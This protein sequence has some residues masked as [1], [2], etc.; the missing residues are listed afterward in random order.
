[1]FVVNKWPP[2]KP[3]SEQCRQTGPVI[4]RVDPARPP[5]QSPVNTPQGKPQIMNLLFPAGRTKG[6]LEKP[7]V[8]VIGHSERV[9]TQRAGALEQDLPALGGQEMGTMQKRRVR[10]GVGILHI[11]DAAGLLGKQ[12]G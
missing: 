11:Q 2:R 3:M 1:V 6:L 7:D 4:G 9:G 8:E 5:P 10:T 12:H